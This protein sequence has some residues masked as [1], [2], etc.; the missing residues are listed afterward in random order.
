MV[1]PMSVASANDSVL[2]V[3]DVQD[4]LAVAMERVDAV[5]ASI[6]L[7][8]RGAAIVGAP[9]IVT[10]QYP[11]GLGDTH[12][13][14]ARVLEEVSAQGATV[15]VVDK[16]SF[17]CFA[18]E[19]FAEAVSDTGRK[20]LLVAGMETHICVTQTVLAGLGA[21][22]DVHVAA[23]ACCSRERDSHDVALKRLTA[24]GSVAS[25]SE[26]VVYELIGRAGTPEFKRLLAAVK[27]AHAAR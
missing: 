18:E 3:I 24:A 9:I 27:A 15:R 17:D 8:V 1:P 25:V 20:Q 22:Y 26:S 2:V 5:I 19:G 11:Q 21:G 16:M 23:D 13:G 10:R 14:V 6:G 4:K 7:L 12:A